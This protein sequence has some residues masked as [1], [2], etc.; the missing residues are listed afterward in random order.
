MADLAGVA[1]KLQAL[2]VGAVT[3][4][5][6]VQAHGDLTDPEFPGARPPSCGS[7]S[8]KTSP[9]CGTDVPSTPSDGVS[10]R[11]DARPPENLRPVAD[12]PLAPRLL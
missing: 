2:A 7:P 6:G 10:F 1:T 3:G 4:L 8:P 9:A 12:L 11:R 5:K